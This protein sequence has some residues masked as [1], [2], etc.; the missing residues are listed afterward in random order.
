MSI[1]IVAEKVYGPASDGNTYRYIRGYCDSDDV[2]PTEGIAEGS[3][4]IETDSDYVY[5][6]EEEKQT[7]TPKYKVTDRGSG[8]GSSGG[9]GGGNCGCFA[10]VGYSV[11]ANDPENDGNIILQ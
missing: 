11:T 7:W 9:S 10:L 3:K 2:K 4:L 1:R 8:G 6:F 5:V